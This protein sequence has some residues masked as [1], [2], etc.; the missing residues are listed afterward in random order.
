MRSRSRSRTR[1]CRPWAA[2]ARLPTLLPVHFP[3][4]DSVGYTRCEH[5]RKALYRSTGTV[6]CEDCGATHVNNLTWE[7]GSLDFTRA[8]L[9]AYE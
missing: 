2:V 1:P 9:V 3:T 7:G 5:P 6:R 8:P 4:L